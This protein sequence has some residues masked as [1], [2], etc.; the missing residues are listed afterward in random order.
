MTAK[1]V[2]RQS[3]PGSRATPPRRR[4]PLVFRVP[5]THIR[6]VERSDIGEG[7]GPA[8]F[9]D[10]LNPGDQHFSLT[11]F[12]PEAFIPENFYAIGASAGAG[13]SHERGSEFRRCG[14]N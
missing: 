3:I 4:R 13:S 10:Q 2:Q 12:S 7:V 9:L 5:E 11:V 14:G 8:G 1:I 6:R